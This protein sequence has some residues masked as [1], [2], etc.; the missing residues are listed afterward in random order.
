VTLVKWRIHHRGARRMASL[1]L[2]VAST[3]LPGLIGGP[4]PLLGVV[5]PVLSWVDQSELTTLS[6]ARPFASSDVFNTPIAAD[7]EIDPNSARW[8]ALLERDAAAANLA[9]NLQWGIPVYQTTQSDP[10]YALAGSV[11]YTSDYFLTHVP[12][13]AVANTGADQHLVVLGDGVET[14]FWGFSRSSDGTPRA[15]SIWQNPCG[16][17]SSFGQCP[18]PLGNAAAANATRIALLAGLVRPLEIAGGKIEHA[19]AFTIPQV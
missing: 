2:T 15:W 18:S 9:N 4:R 5:A 12:R 19:L 17:F 7:P 16:P 3:I 1:A 14:D 10:A 11:Y 8:V 6:S 13:T